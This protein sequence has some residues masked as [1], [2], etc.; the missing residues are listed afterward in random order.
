MHVLSMYIC[1]LIPL[2]SCCDGDELTEVGVELRAVDAVILKPG[3]VG[4]LKIYLD[5]KKYIGLG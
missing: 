2:T 3:I 5:R 4:R 1:D